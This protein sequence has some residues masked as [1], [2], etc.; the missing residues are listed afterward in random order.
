[1]FHVINRLLRN[2]PT[3]F[4]KHKEKIAIVDTTIAILPISSGA[5][6]VEAKRKVAI[7][8]AN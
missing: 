2:I 8:S 3:G 6:I 7:N 1:L 4:K 5:K